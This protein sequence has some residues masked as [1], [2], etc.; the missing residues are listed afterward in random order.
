MKFLSELGLR[1]CKFD[2]TTL[3]F[4]P[5]AFQRLKASLVLLLIA[6]FSFKY[7]V[8]QAG[9]SHSIDNRQCNNFFTF[10]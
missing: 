3:R 7:Y 2:L 9:R 5:S 10:F 4:E 8:L 6:S 1:A